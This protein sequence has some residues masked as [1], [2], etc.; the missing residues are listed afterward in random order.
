MKNSKIVAAMTAA[1]LTVSMMAMPAFADKTFTSDV[2]G[3][4]ADG[5]KI[6]YSFTDNGYDPTKVETITFTFEVDD[7]ESF[8]GGIMLQSNLNEWDQ[9]DGEWDWGKSDKPIVA[10]GSNGVYTLTFDLTDY[11]ANLG[12]DIEWAQVVVQTW[13]GNDINVTAVDVKTAA[14]EEP[15]DEDPTDGETTDGETTD[16]ETTAEDDY[17]TGDLDGNGKIDINDIV[18]LAAHI[19]GKRI[20]SGAALKAADVNGD[21]KININDL[22][23]VA[24]HVKGKRLLY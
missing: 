12:G 21:G 24:A 20:L 6:T 13:W 11:Y 17:T 3:V 15:V 9:R 7:S 18:K 8:N 14:S 19:K 5:N 4:V 16:G 10:E 22:V 23:K 2:E 1:A